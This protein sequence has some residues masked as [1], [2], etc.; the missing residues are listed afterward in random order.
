[1]FQHDRLSNEITLFQKIKNLDYI[2]LI[3]VILL[4]LL[5]IFVMYST[6]GGEILFHTKN[7]F[8]KLAVFFPL[9]I[10]VAF[11][12]IKFWHNFSYLIYFIVILL[13]ISPQYRV[14]KLY[15]QKYPFFNAK[16]LAA[17]QRLCLMSL[18]L[19][20]KTICSHK[21]LA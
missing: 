20:T 19:T 12:N 9:M 18:P 4:S 7:H 11:F 5:S 3:S 10:F 6:D 1:M 15:R 21:F 13:L 17:I 16:V 2:L 8:V 14:V